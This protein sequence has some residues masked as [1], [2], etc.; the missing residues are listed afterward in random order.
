MSSAAS[1][2]RLRLVGADDGP[3]RR[4]WARSRRVRQAVIRENRRAAQNPTLEPTDPR[5]V[6]AVRAHSQLQGATLT[7]DRRERVMR[8]ARLLGVRPFDASLII[9]IVQDQ[10][11]RGEDL[12]GA[13]GT[14]ALIHRPQRRWRRTWVWLRWIAAVA[15]ALMANALL[16]WWLLGTH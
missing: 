14:L 5:W 4:D 1:H 9:A 13:A 16:I 2:P 7:P 6:L 15:A 12:A 8:T 3:A 10:A 11:R